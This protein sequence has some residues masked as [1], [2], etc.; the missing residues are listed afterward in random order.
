MIEPEIAGTWRVAEVYKEDKEGKLI[1]YSLEGFDWQYA[2]ES[3]MP[4]GLVVNFHGDR[5]PDS[6]EPLSIMELD[7]MGDKTLC[8]H[9]S[10]GWRT[11]DC[12]DFPRELIREFTL[13]FE[14]D[15]SEVELF[16]AVG[17]GKHDLLYQVRLNGSDGWDCRFYVAKDHKTMWS[18]L[19][20]QERKDG[21]GI[22]GTVSG[23]F[24]RWVRLK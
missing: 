13:W 14:R 5:G 8:K 22:P 23:G 1:P 9:K 17:A 3:V 19:L 15:P 12:S 18:E 6:G 10:F 11:L 21:R 16:K 7:T 2:D 20:F 4:I 24:Q